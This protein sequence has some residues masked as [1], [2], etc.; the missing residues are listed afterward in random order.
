ML[1]LID[2][3]DYK[4]INCTFYNR[5]S[6]YTSHTKEPVFYF[7]NYFKY[8]STA[9][10]LQADTTVGIILVTALFMVHFRKRN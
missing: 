3:G 5:G 4:F 8:S 1:H 10:A 2:G 6:S 9:P 7:N